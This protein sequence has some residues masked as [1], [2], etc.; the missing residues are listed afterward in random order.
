MEMIKNGDAA[1]TKYP[2]YST[3]AEQSWYVLDTQVQLQSRG[4]DALKADKKWTDQ[5]NLWQASIYPGHTTPW[6]GATYIMKQ[7]A[8]YGVLGASFVNSGGGDLEK[9]SR[10][11]DVMWLVR[12]T[13]SFLLLPYPRSYWKLGRLSGVAQRFLCYGRMT[14]TICMLDSPPQIGERQE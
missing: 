2:D 13:L 1:Q 4:T 10:L 11:S 8:K 12:S 5:F 7:N 3:L 14:L 6:H 9:L